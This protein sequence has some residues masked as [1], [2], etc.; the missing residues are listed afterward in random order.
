[1]KKFDL[2]RESWLRHTIIQ[3]PDL[4]LTLYDL[5]LLLILTYIYFLLLVCEA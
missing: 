5:G 4:L 1:M 3:M 2:K